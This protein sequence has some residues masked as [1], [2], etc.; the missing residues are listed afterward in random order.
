MNDR[1]PRTTI[2]LPSIVV[3]WLGHEK[4]DRQHSAGGKPKPANGMAVTRDGI[5]VEAVVLF[6]HVLND[7]T[8]TQIFGPEASEVQGKLLSY[9]VSNQQPSR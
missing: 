2:T 8:M 4:V 9:L 5:I 6:S 1:H 7:R 3:S